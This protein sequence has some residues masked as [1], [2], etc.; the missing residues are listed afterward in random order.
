MTKSLRIL[1][2]AALVLGALAA[3]TAVYAQGT[4]TGGAAA[5]TATATVGAATSGGAAV[6]ATV[7]PSTLPRTGGDTNPTSTATIVLLALGATA[8]LGGLLLRGL[9]QP[10]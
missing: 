9:R 3:V 6:S 10:R 8:G 5:A 1:L 4:T 2:V 7:T